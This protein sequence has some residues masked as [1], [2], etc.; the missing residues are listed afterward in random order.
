MADTRLFVSERG[1]PGAFPLIALHG[2]PGLDHHMFADYL[3]PITHAGRYRLILVD[4]RAQGRSNR[5]T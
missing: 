2:G 1:D 5:P 4:E 3:D